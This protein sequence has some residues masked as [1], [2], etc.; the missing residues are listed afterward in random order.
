MRGTSRY[1]VFEKGIM[2]S[3]N[4]TKNFVFV[5]VLIFCCLSLNACGIVASHYKE[6]NK[7]ADKPEDFST[8][9]QKPQIAGTIESKEITESSGLVASNCNAGVFWTNNDSGDG[10]FIY[11]FDGQGKKLGTWKVAGAENDDWEDMATFKNASGECFL[12]LGDIGN[13]ELLRSKLMIYKIK[14]P[15]ISADSS[16][17]TRKNPLST[18]SAQKIEFSYSDASNNAE[19]LLVHPQTE[20]IY[21]LSKNVNNAASIYKLAPKF[22]TTAKA[23]KLGDFSVPAIPVGLLTGA[24]ISPD[25]RR[26]A[27]CDYFNGYEIVLPETAKSFDEI[28]KQ[29]PMKIDLGER[30]QGEAITYSPDGKTLYATSEKKNPPLI[31]VSRK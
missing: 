29:K 30:K 21:I 15:T 19:S 9:Y 4:I 8:D 24:A 14:E 3:S 25:G 27:I 6:R 12:Y 28:W 31:S 10:A 20:D 18:E 1:N 16:D 17:S 7:E 22:E 13:N 26:V 5:T 11:A 2:S 23:E